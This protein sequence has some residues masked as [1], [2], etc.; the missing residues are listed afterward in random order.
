[1]DNSPSGRISILRGTN[2]EWGTPGSTHTGGCNVLL[3]DGSV[4][5]LSENLDG[6]TRPEIWA[7]SQT[8]TRSA[9]SKPDLVVSTS[10]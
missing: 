6:S 10:T 5:F 1:M 2:G 9:T 4:K 3:A 8:V 7:I